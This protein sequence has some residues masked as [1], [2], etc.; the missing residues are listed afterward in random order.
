[1]QGTQL[2]GTLSKMKTA[3]QSQVEY[4]LP[5]GEER[6]GLNAY[7]GKPIKLTHTNQIFCTHCGRKTKR[8]CKSRLC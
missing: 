2:V 7:L 5:V 8:S 6:L 1:M 3:L 4:L